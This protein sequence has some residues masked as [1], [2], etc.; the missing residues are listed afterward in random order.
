MTTHTNDC[1]NCDFRQVY[2]EA[3]DWPEG[4]MKPIYVHKA[5]YPRYVGSRSPVY[6]AVDGQQPQKL[7]GS[8]PQVSHTFGYWENHYAYANEHGLTIG[9][10][11]CAANFQSTSDTAMMSIRELTQ[12]AM[13][14][15]RTARCAVDAMGSVAE[16][17]GF[18]GED[19]GLPGGG[20]SLTIGDGREVWVFHITGDPTG[21]S[22]FWA[23]QRVPDGHVVV[24]ANGF[25]LRELQCD[26]HDDFLCSTDLPQKAVAAKVWDGKGLL[27]WNL[28]MGPDLRNFSYTPGFA[29][30]P[31]YTSARLWRV[32]SLV[33]PSLKMKLTVD[34][35]DYPFF[36]TRRPE[37]HRQRY[38][39]HPA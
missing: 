39:G 14:R 13:E 28:A 25:V 8:I 11:T 12:I 35:H 19:P 6:A 24:I 22:A 10:S 37:T 26:K 1:Q 3:R 36:C 38:T 33:A 2:I 30:I 16:R 5:E 29:P 23:A 9:E 15:C 17:F 21:R 32:F 27:D 7:L 20:E 18:Y 4:T 34:P 31:L